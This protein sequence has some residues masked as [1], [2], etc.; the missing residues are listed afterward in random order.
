MKT[1][2]FS[3]LMEE[4]QRWRKCHACYQNVR[5]GRSF[6]V[7]NY[8]LCEKHI[9]CARCN[10]F[11][12][13]DIWPCDGKL[14]CRNCYLL[15]VRSDLC[16]SCCGRIVEPALEKEGCVWH[17]S[18]FVCQACRKDF[19]DENYFMY[20]NLPFCSVHFQEERNRDKQTAR[21]SIEFREREISE[22]L[23]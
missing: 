22:E 7:A 14:Y 1:R 12:H 8:V 9:C 15:M 16:K 4:S 10:A 11:I 13:M 3:Y 2:K 19:I 5:P 18:C 17:Y 21:L 23:E 20:K 6:E